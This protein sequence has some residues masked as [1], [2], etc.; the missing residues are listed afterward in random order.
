MES[1][2]CRPRSYLEAA[3]RRVLPYALCVITLVACENQN[4]PASL[5]GPERTSLTYD[6]VERAGPGDLSVVTWNVYYGADL[7]VLIGASSL[8]LPVRVAQVFGQ[9]QATNA[10]ERA[11]AMAKLIAA[12]SPDLVGLQEVARYRVQS[13]GDFLD[14]SGGILN[15][16]PNATTDV[17]DFLALLR[18]ALHTE[19]VDYVEASRTTTFDVELPM[20]TGGPCPPCDDLRLTESVAILAR[21]DVS[22]SNPDG[23]VYSVNLPISVEGFSLEIVKG[24]ASVDVTVKGTTR[25][26]VTTHVEPADIG[27]NHAVIPEVEQI[28]LAQAAELLGVLEEADVP[29]IVTGDL[30]T[31]PDGATTDTYELMRTAGFVD[32]WTVGRR[33]GDGF[34]ANQAADLLN[35]ESQLSHRID[36]V[37]YRDDATVERDAFRGAVHAELLGEAQADRTVSGLWPSDHAGVHAWLSPRA[38]VASR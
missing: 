34:T 15:P 13:P 22:V 30:N 11:A 21:S 20:Y 2:L 38:G 37:L 23:D 26:F 6:G 7:D 31:D 33:R 29:V 10:P 18:D 16:Y 35:A 8:P 14:G 12:A 5:L 1:P 9:V 27:P 32:T 36:F 19:G 25:R 3:V 24:W 17:I 4:D 28:Q